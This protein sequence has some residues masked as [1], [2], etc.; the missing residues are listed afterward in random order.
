[1]KI[2]YKIVY[3]NGKIYVGK[4]LT[5]SINYFGSASSEL[6]AADFT[7]EQRREFVIRREILWEST[8]APD[9]E[10]SRKEVEFIQLLRSNDPAVGYNQSPKFRSVPQH[11]G[12]TSRPRV[13][14]YLIYGLID[15][16]DRCL[17]Y[18]GK[19]H[20]RRELRLAEHIGLATEGRGAPV[21]EW[22]RS[23]LGES[24]EPEIFVLERVAPGGDWASAEQSAISRWRG[25]PPGALPYIHPPQT[26]KSQPVRIEAVHLVNVRSG[27]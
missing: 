8:T 24:L 3:P 22:I 20:K 18:I 11:R 12:S 25:W 27:G 1:M 2:I 23:L 21:Y 9:A 13:G 17:R 15:P 4:D 26:P 14:R 6:I 16:R 7:V 5:N 10:V 19:T